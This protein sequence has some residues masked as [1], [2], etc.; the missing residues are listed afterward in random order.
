MSVKIRKKGKKF[1][2]F[3]NY[4]GQRKAKCIGTSRQLA[5][6][7]KRQLES[8]LTL[9]D[10]GFLNDKK[11]A[12]C[13]F[14]QKMG[15]L[16]DKKEA[17]CTF[18]QYAERW[19]KQHAELHC[20][21]STL[22]GYR[23]VLRLYLLPQ[24]G[25]SPLE[26][27][28]RDDIKQFFAALAEK[29]LAAN[30]LKNALIVLRVILNCAIEDGFIQVNPANKM[31]RFLPADRDKFEAVALTREEAEAFLDA[32]KELYPDRYSLFLAILRTGMRWGEVVA[33]RWGDIQFGTSEAD[34]N[35]FIWVRRNWVHGKFTTPKSK[36]AR[37][38]DLSRQLRGVLL[39]LRDTRMLDAYLNGRTNIADELVFP[40]S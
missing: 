31:A 9:G 18:S 8:K 2:V 17:R 25:P 21:L 28:G 20:K 33:L 35:R 32:L 7:V 40:S 19:L 1:Y 22:Q 23:G 30:T 3:V 14:S 15:F 36:K 37:R 16:N 13:T 6:Q 11:E 34:S 24:F 26:R 5:E 10:L 4:H 29:G 27:I 39:E 12:R 38:I